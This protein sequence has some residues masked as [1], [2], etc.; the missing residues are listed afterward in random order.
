MLH[1]A[2]Y[3]KAAM[4][5]N[6]WFAKRSR[7]RLRPKLRDHAGTIEF[8]AATGIAS[9]DHASSADLRVEARPRAKRKPIPAFV[10]SDSAA[11]KHVQN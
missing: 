11:V 7:K 4:M 3:Q 1:P 2:L 6:T 8:V 9:G 5:Y 10:G